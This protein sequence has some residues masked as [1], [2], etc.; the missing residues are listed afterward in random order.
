LYHTH[1]NIYCIIC[2]IIRYDYHEEAV[3]GDVKVD[4]RERVARVLV[5][6]QADLGM[7]QG[8]EQSLHRQITTMMAIII[9][10][11][12]TAG[13]EFRRQLS[14]WTGAMTMI[15]TATIMIMQ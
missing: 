5:V 14:G 10:W 4:R 15:V 2:I 13:P 8:T 11:H 12:R 6:P 1:H 3:D 7:H 9:Y